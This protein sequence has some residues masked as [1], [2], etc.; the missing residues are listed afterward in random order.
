M[1]NEARDLVATSSDI[2]IPNS[3]REFDTYMDNVYKVTQ[4]ME[5]EPAEK[6]KIGNQVAG[7]RIQDSIVMSEFTRSKLDISN[8]ANCRHQFVL[9]IGA[10]QSEINHHNDEVKRVYRE[11]MFGYNHRP[12][13]RKGLTKPK[14]GECLSR[15][16]ACLCCRMHYLNRPDG[17]GYLKFEWAC[18][19]QNKSKLPTE[20]R[21]HFDKNSDCK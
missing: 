16:L 13:S 21:A 8:C 7:K 10:D 9:P 20:R 11:R 15:K 5:N 12:R 2:L 17:V 14:M 6:G 19:E 18:I 4:I 1:I 3:I